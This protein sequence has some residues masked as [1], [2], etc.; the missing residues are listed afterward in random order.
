MRRYSRVATSAVVA[1]LALMLILS[2]ASAGR[3]WCRADP[4]IG[5][6]DANVR[7]WVEIPAEYE[8]LV[9]GP[10]A[11]VVNHP[12]Q[13]DPEVR[14]TDSGFNGFGEV[15]SFASRDTN[16][17]AGRVTYSERAEMSI[18]ASVPLD[19]ARLAEEFGVR[20]GRIPMRMI[21]LDAA[22]REYVV[23]GTSDG[24]SQTISVELAS[25]AGW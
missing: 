6:G 22:G 10:I 21:I 9:T 3:M 2:P 16:A 15:V 19:T 8:Q 1:G 13:L 18:V 5:Y 7:I 20:S 25:Y 14:F 24:A 17:A 12:S 23:N 4:V 11:F